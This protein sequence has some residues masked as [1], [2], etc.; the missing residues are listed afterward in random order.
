MKKSAI[1]Q[2]VDQLMGAGESIHTVSLIWSIL[3]PRLPKE[4]GVCVEDTSVTG[5]TKRSRP[6]PHQFVNAL[7]NIIGNETATPMSGGFDVF[8]T[9]L[10]EARVLPNKSWLQR[11]AVGLR[12]NA[13]HSGC[14]PATALATRCGGIIAEWLLGR[15]LKNDDSHAISTPEIRDMN[16][17]SYGK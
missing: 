1:L 6:L 5:Y 14:Q 2:S 3:M 4:Y 16:L 17:K 9:D 15:G 7:K 13:R 10:M 12:A 11:E 8:K